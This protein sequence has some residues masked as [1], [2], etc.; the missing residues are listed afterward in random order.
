LDGAEVSS[1]GLGEP[2]EFHTFLAPGRG[3][4]YDH[5]HR[6]IPADL[7]AVMRAAG[8]IAWRIY[9]NDLILAH[10]V[11]ALDRQH[12]DEILD[13]DPV[14]Q[15]WQQEVAPYLVDTP[16]TEIGDDPGDLVWDFSWPTR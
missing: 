7:D 5:F 11:V 3:P 13:M 4:A 16:A 10:Q 2:F 14:N 15:R 12:M 6:A 8:V 1:A 9:R